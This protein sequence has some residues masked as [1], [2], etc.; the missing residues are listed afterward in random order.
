MLF[1]S[2]FALPARADAEKTGALVV[3]VD[4]GHGGPFPLDGAHGV[5]G[6]VEKTVALQVALRLKAELEGAGATVVLTRD[7]DVEVTLAQRAQLANEANADL[8]V[9]V[10]CNSMATSADRKV[11]KGVE[12]YFLSPDPTD[13]EAKLL[14]ELENGGPDALPVPKT[15]DKVQGL[16][17]DLALGQARN[18]SMELAATVH[19]Q[20]IRR[21]GANSRGVR[22]A[23]FLVLWGVK[24]PA[25]L[26]EIGFISHPQ[27]G[28]A[29]TKEKVQQKIAEAIAAG[30]RDFADKVLARRLFPPTAE[31]KAARAAEKEAR[32]QA[33]RAAA[34][35]KKAAEAKA[36][37]GAEAEPG[38]VARAEAKA[39]DAGRTS[40]E[41]KP[42]VNAKELEA[43]PLG[44]QSGPLPEQDK[45]P[46][47]GAPVKL[48]SPVPR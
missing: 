47:A 5:K 19:R 8:F 10:H 11:T 6:L 17:A 2:S 44:S 23:P 41:A 12:T 48:L 15:T 13:A 27:E 21:T 28:K 29:L 16:L 42:A 30:V 38:A 4:P 25:V 36:D 31:E 32:Q 35:A 1:Y 22:Q 7:A 34:N 40:T 37:A 14:A 24:M 46:V 39:A 9:S 26:V 20:I 18:D 33:W 45:P 3:V 43:K